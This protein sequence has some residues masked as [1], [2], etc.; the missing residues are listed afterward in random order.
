MSTYNMVVEKANILVFPDT[1][2]ENVEILK[3]CA[4]KELLANLEN[5]CNTSED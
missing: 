5:S 3:S 4:S 1:L 2:L